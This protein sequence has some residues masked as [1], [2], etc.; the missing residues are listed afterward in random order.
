MDWFSRLVLSWS[1]SVTLE[2]DFCLAA[3]KQALRQGGQK[4]STATRDRNS[5]RKSSPSSQTHELPQAGANLFLVSR[6]QLPRPFLDQA[7]VESE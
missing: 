6:T 2:L 5:P 1:P 3:L 7:V 4:S